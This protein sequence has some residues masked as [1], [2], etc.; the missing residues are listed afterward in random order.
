MLAARQ[1]SLPT[2]FKSLYRLTLR[3]ASAAVLHHPHAT[4]YLRQLYRPA[5]EDAIGA[6][7]RLQ[8]ASSSPH[9]R[10]DITLLRNWY[11]EWGHRVD[12]ALSLMYHASTARGLP[13][14]L[15][16]NLGLLSFSERERLNQRVFPLWRADGQQKTLGKAQR[17]T[18]KER[19]YAWTD[20]GAWSS[21]EQVARMAEG[22]HGMS[23][24]RIQVK[25]SAWRTA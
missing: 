18:E 7:T 16:R 15:T 10:R 8:A 23:L 12:N 20:Q 13:H 22:R 25:R 19:A 5:F 11:V 17:K 2:T 4:R 14:R 3:T 6:V 1:I 21:V 9:T 24:G